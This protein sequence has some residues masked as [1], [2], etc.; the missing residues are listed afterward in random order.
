MGK[1][2]TRKTYKSKGIH[3]ATTNGMLQALRKQ[4]SPLAVLENKVAA[5]RKGQN[6]WLTVPTSQKNK[7]FIRIRADEYWGPAKFKK[8]ASLV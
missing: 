7:P 1:K 8:K 6:P 5:W 3:S 4:R 2:R